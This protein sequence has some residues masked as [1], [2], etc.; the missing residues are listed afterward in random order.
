MSPKPK[1]N[2][3]TQPIPNPLSFCWLIDVKKRYSLDWWVYRQYSGSRERGILNVAA[4]MVNLCILFQADLKLPN[5]NTIP[6][7]APMGD[8]N[9]TS[10]TEPSSGD[11]PSG[12]I[13]ILGSPI[14]VPSTAP[15]QNWDQ[16]VGATGLEQTKQQF[17][18]KLYNH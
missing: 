9:D 12:E 13:P 4:L 15:G 14:P 10:S 16:A 5:Q 17:K 3:N 7:V 8:V 6:P 11:S 2:L 1:P 18:W